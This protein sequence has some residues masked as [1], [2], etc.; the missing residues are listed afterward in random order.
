MLDFV[1]L[2]G[3]DKNICCRCE[4]EVS[5]TVSDEV[6]SFQEARSVDSFYELVGSPGALHP[7][8]IERG[9]AFALLG[10]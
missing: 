7:D 8:L 2:E 9:R 10:E 5:V 6:L 3:V 4:R 1:E